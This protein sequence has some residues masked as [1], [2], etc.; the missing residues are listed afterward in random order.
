M[1]LGAA[2]RSFH[3]LPSLRGHPPVGTPP[4]AVAPQPARPQPQ[5]QPQCPERGGRLVRLPCGAEATPA[6]PGTLAAAAARPRPEPL[7]VCWQPGGGR[8]AAASSR[9]TRVSFSAHRKFRRTRAPA[10]AARVVDACRVLGGDASAGGAGMGMPEPAR[11]DPARILQNRPRE[12]SARVEG[13]CAVSASPQQVHEAMKPAVA[14]H[15]V[16]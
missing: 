16:S 10:A 2:S 7:G 3:P 11:L 15:W 8:A 4:T 9:A 14:L 12:R 13:R 1:P 6:L 5:P